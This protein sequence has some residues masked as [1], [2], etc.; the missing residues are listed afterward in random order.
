MPASRSRCPQ[1]V[2]GDPGSA[3]R[4]GLEAAIADEHDRRTVEQGAGPPAT[5]QQ[6]NQSLHREEGRQGH[7]SATEGQHRQQRGSPHNGPDREQTG[8]VAE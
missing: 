8:E 3:Q 5:A 1:L 4:F 6:P 2:G 7:D